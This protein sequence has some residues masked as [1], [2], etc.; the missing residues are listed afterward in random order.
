MSDCLSRQRQ[1]PHLEGEVSLVFVRRT[2]QTHHPGRYHLSVFRFFQMWSLTA[3]TGAE[4]RQIIAVEPLQKCRSKHR[5]CVCRYTV[6]VCLHFPCARVMICSRMDACF[7]SPT[8]L[9]WWPLS[10]PRWQDTRD[11]SGSIKPQRS[12]FLPEQ[13]GAAGKSLADVKRR[14]WCLHKDLC[15]S[16][17]ISPSSARL[18]LFFFYSPL[19]PERQARS[20]NNLLHPAGRAPFTAP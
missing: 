19:M 6:H 17:A 2:G 18:L 16:H 14:H 8:T 13:D 20:V 11:Y 7:V 12:D 10:N 15:V 1:R 5:K 3:P 4:Y 9:R